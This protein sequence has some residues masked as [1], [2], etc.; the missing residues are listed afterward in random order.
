VKFL[1][2]NKD[3]NFVKSHGREPDKF[4]KKQGNQLYAYT[5]GVMF[6]LKNGPS[7]VNVT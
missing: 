3:K 6:I 2:A 1:S 5:V 7:V 4:V